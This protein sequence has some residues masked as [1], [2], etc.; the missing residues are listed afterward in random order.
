[1]F[2]FSAEPMEPGT[3]FASPT[4]QRNCYIKMIILMCRCIEKWIST[5]EERAM[6]NRPKGDYSSERL[7]PPAR[8]IKG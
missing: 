8:E 7:T 1:M 2:H 5:V 4:V 6:N 3:E